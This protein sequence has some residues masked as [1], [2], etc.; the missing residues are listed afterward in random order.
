M[1][2]GLGVVVDA[3][4]LVLRRGGVGLQGEVRR[5]EEL[6]QLL[7]LVE[8]LVEDIEESQADLPLLH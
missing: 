5:E 8:F 7:A 6:W 2:Q 4:L 3:L 1:L